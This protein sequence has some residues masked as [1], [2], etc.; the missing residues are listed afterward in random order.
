MEQKESLIIAGG[1]ELC[2]TPPFIYVNDK[3]KEEIDTKYPESK[4]YKK[5]YVITTE[6]YGNGELLNV[7]EIK[8]DFSRKEAQKFCDEKSKQKIKCRFSKVIRSIDGYV[9]KHWTENFYMEKIA[10]HARKA[11]RKFARRKLK[12]KTLYPQQGILT[13]RCSSDIP[14]WI[15]EILSKNEILNNSNAISSSSKFLNKIL[16][17]GRFIY[18]HKNIGIIKINNLYT[19]TTYSNFDSKIAST[20]NNE[21]L[22]FK[23]QIGIICI[24]SNNLD[25]N[26]FRELQIGKFYTN[27]SLNKCEALK[28][29]RY[30]E[31]FVVRSN[32]N[33]L[34]FLYQYSQIPTDLDGLGMDFFLKMIS[35]SLLTYEY[36]DSFSFKNRRFNRIA[37]N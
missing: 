31:A 23:G 3:I 15:S 4:N 2:R 5:F 9:E 14:S 33:L 20:F 28:Y 18:S 11:R 17:Q 25:F 30:Q 12:R 13:E 7:I 24:N 10:E 37:Y 1:N 21:L 22:L 26:K 29:L 16:E 27:K 32:E 36:E 34:I 6:A 8:N 35:K 19:Q